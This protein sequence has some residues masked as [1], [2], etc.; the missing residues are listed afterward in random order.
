MTEIFLE[1]FIEL[2][3]LSGMHGYIILRS[4]QSPES[5]KYWYHVDVFCKALSDDWKRKK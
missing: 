2:L 5:I 3:N 4:V 1:I